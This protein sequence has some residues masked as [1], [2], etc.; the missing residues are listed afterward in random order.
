MSDDK[1]FI[2][3]ISRKR[4]SSGCIID[5]SLKP[6]IS[7]SLTIQSI[8]SGAQFTSIGGKYYQIISRNAGTSEN[9]LEAKHIL[10]SSDGALRLRAG[11]SLKQTSLFSN[12]GIQTASSSPISRRPTVFLK[13]PTPKPK[14]IRIITIEN[15]E[16]SP[17][18]YIGLS[19]EPLNVL[20]NVISRVSDIPTINLYL[21]LKKIRLNEDFNI[22]S[23][24]FELEEAEAQRIFA[25]TVVKLAKYMKSLVRWPDSKKYY[26][27][28]KNLPIAFRSRLYHVQSLVECVDTEFQPRTMHPHDLQ[29]DSLNCDKLKFLLALSPNGAISYISDM[30]AANRFTNDLSVFKASDFKKN[31]P[32][33]LSLVADPGKGVRTQRNLSTNPLETTDTEDESE[34]IKATICQPPSLSTISVQNG[35]LSTSSKDYTVPTI[36][37]P[38]NICRVQIRNLLYFLRDFKI[39]QP[40]ASLEPSLYQ[41]FNEI[42]VIISGVT[43]LQR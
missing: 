3:E 28:H 43:N 24:D 16:K 4:S 29:L 42:L 26:D 12:N 31:I 40:Y 38:N 32:T 22:L 1:Q 15:I 35:H 6:K 8:G 33:Y 17:L 11:S 2:S 10:K 5:S 13:T 7:K 20:K 37:V 39:L 21:T 41:Y 27:R 36:Q 34:H 18:Q 23:D 30:F 14:T 25:I 9:N 19:K